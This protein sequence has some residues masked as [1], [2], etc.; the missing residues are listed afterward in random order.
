MSDAQGGSVPPPGW[1]AGPSITTYTSVADIAPRAAPFAPTAIAEPQP[2]IASAQPPTEAA[3]RWRLRAA[4]ID[5]LLVDALYVVICLVLHW[6]ALTVGHL[7]VLLALGVVYHF[8]LESHG[9]QTIGK[10]RYGI[11]VVSVHGGPATPKGI[12]LR[13]LLRAIDSLPFWYLSGLISMVRTG[14]ERRQRIGDVAGETKVIAVDGRSVSRGTP[15]WWLPTA[16]L[17]ALAFSCLGVY[18]T[19][20]AGSGALS[21]GQEAAFVTDCQNAVGGVVG[22]QCLLT[23]LEADGYDSANSINTVFEQAASERFYGQSGTA[24]TELTTDAQACRQ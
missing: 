24:R 5:N 20:E 4:T 11:Q 2:A 9:G 6:Q 1:S 10:R 17:L 23:R 12:A 21:S 16:T 22:C 13:S 15:S 14:P 8:V 19:V 3:I 7:L 18:G